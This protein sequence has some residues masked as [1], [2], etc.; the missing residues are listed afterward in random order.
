MVI[1]YSYV[2]LP[3]GTTSV[4]RKFTMFTTVGNPSKAEPLT[5]LN[6]T[7]KKGLLEEGD[8]ALKHPNGDI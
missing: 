8:H 2:S 7:G 1:F 6:S 5:S 3:E 4:A